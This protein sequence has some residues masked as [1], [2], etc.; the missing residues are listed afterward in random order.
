MQHMV[1][2]LVHVA[3]IY[4]YILQKKNFSNRNLN[5]I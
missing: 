4:A 3:E 1:V 2:K 5:N